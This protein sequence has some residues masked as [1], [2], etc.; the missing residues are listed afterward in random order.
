MKQ[1]YLYLAYWE[2]GN[3]REGG[4]AAAQIEGYS[5]FDPDHNKHVKSGGEVLAKDMRTCNLVDNITH[6]LRK[7]SVEGGKTAELQHSEMRLVT[8]FTKMIPNLYESFEPDK[9]F[10]YYV[11]LNFFRA[12]QQE[13]GPIDHWLNIRLQNAVCTGIAMHHGEGMD[14][15]VGSGLATISF[16]YQEFNLTEFQDKT[17]GG[18]AVTAN[19]PWRK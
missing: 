2:G 9:N 1:T 6:S 19:I 11:E 4:K 15:A 17:K 13:Q 3:V 18:G 16:S 5:I 14:S 10:R 12:G 8:G 7:S